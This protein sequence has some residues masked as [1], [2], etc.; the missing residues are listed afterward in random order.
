MI[1]RL[2]LRQLQPTQ[3]RQPLAAAAAAAAA[4]VVVVVGRAPHYDDDRWTRLTN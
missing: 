3:E 2:R 1:A 4:V